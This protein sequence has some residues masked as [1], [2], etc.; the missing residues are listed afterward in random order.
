MSN[1]KFGDK[2]KVCSLQQPSKSRIRYFDKV[3][4]IILLG[5]ETPNGKYGVSF[6]DIAPEYFFKEELK[7]LY[8]SNNIDTLEMLE[9]LENLK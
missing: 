8:T 5:T 1:F 9:Q 3:G 7:L 2:V 6:N 4:V